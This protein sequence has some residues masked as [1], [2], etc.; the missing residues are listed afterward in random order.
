MISFEKHVTF[1]LG[2]QKLTIIM[3]VAHFIMYSKS[4]D[5]IIVPFYFGE[6]V[7]LCHETF[8]FSFSMALACYSN[9][10]RLALELLC[11]LRVSQEIK[12]RKNTCDFYFERTC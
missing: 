8:P 7:A 1:V 12:F 3:S 4:L 10:E 2:H 11:L 6:S 5:G 9:N